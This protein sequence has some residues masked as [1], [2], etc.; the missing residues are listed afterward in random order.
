MTYGTEVYET[1]YSPAKMQ[2]LK[3]YLHHAARKGR[4]G[5]GASADQSYGQLLNA[6]Q[7]RIAAL[8]EAHPS[9]LSAGSAEYNDWRAIVD[10]AVAYGESVSY[11]STFEQVSGAI[12]KIRASLK[13]DHLMQKIAEEVNRTKRVQC[14]DCTGV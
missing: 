10:I 12:E 3:T 14:E 7:R 6:A 9:G 1:G 5:Q 11:G 4:L 8:K 13:P 2:E